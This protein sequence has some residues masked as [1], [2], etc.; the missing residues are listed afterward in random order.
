MESVREEFTL[1]RKNPTERISLLW[2]TLGNMIG[3]IVFI[4]VPYYVA[5]IKKKTSPDMLIKH[6][7]I[8]HRS[9]SPVSYFHCLIILQIQSRS[10]MLV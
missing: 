6:D 4:A 5:S 10:V 7:E 9:D 3:G 8:G 2:V 1:H